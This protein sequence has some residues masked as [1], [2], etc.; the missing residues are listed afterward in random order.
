DYSFSPYTQSWCK[1]NGAADSRGMPAH[2][3]HSHSTHTL[4][5][6][7]SLT[8]HTLYTSR[9]TTE[10]NLTGCFKSCK[11]IRLEDNQQLTTTHTVRQHKNT[12]LLSFRFI[13]TAVYFIYNYAHIKPESCIFLLTGTAIYQQFYRH[14]FESS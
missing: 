1:S 2:H 11:C 10:D 6:T 5:H 13:V 4:H 9:S 12:L 8:Q 14:M 3:T 7:H